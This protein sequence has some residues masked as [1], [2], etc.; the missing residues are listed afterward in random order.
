MAAL[1]LTNDAME[2]LERLG[3]DVGSVPKGTHSPLRRAIGKVATL[4]EE[5]DQG[6]TRA[7]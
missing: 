5:R 4:S 3:R 6:S 2:Y 7:R 1:D